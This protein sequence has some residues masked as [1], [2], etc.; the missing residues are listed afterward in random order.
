MKLIYQQMIAFFFIIIT[1]AAIIGYSV[2]SFSSEQ[3]YDSTFA[4]LEGYADSLGEIALKE[5]AITGGYQ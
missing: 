4:R 1:S 5:N 2:L 3:A